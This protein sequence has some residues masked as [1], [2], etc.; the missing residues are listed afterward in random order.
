MTASELANEIVNYVRNN[1]IEMNKYYPESDKW[2]EFEGGAGWLYNEVDI[3]SR[4]INKI[5][6]NLKYVWHHIK[7]VKQFKDA[8]E[9]IPI[10]H[11][12]IIKK[13]AVELEGTTNK[14][15]FDLL[16]YSPEEIKAF[17]KL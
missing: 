3:P 11:L 5:Y 7:D 16:E 9:M 4:L 17:F 6:P 15:T 14:L 8:L 12:E 13:V 1:V 2:D 10:A